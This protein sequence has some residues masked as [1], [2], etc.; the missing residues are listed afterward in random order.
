MTANPLLVPSSLPFGYPDFGAI[1]EEHFVEA[2]ETG[3]AEQRAELAAVTGNPEPATFDNTVVALE[4]SG[5]TL[6]RVSLVFSALVGSC[7]TPGIR[8]IEAE[9]APGLS[10]HRDALTLDPA[11]FARIEAVDADGLDG[12]SRRLLERYHRDRV[13]AGARLGAADQQRLRAL[14]TELSALSTEFGTRLLAEAN[15]SAVHVTDVAELDGLS[16][17]AVS[18]AAQAATARGLDGYL[19]TMVLPT[20]QPVLASLTRRDLRE[21]VHEASVTRGARG[22]ANDV[23]ELVVRI[24]ALRAE[25]AALL[26]HPHHASWTVEDGT[27]G[28]VEALDAMLGKLAP[29][30]TANARAEA[31]ELAAVAGHP[32]EPWDRAFY[33][34]QVRRERFDVDVAALRP[35]FEL[36]RVLHDGVFR[37]AELLYLDGAS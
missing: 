24:A 19:I 32:I 35:Y 14:N 2:F 29:V 5:R 26:G 23:T 20:G 12:E 22:G 13:R 25:R 7:S 34:E 3:M 36:N 21:R 1:R 28:T 31:E 10:A 8:A 37:A 15:D 27:A 18:A 16:P 17:D 4:R 6:R 11:L 30:A 33:A 9:M